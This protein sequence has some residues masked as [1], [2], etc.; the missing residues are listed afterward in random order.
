M[1]KSKLLNLVGLSIFGLL[2]LSFQSSIANAAFPDKPIEIIVPFSAGGG[3]DKLARQ[4]AG[5][6]EKALGVPVVIKNNPG[7]GGRRG[8]VTLFKSKPDGYTIGF[9]HFNPF[10]ADEIFFKKK[11]AVDYK[12][13]AII[14]MVAEGKDLIFVP[15]S[16]SVKTFADLK[17]LNR[18]VK[19]TATGLGAST[20]IAVSALAGAAGFE[21]NFVTGYKNLIAAALGTARGDADAGLGGYRQISGMV[22]ELRPI[23]FF[24]DTREPHFPDVPTVKELGY[25]N[26]AGL[27]SPY[28]ISAP[29]NTPEDRLAVIRKAL[30][31]A[32]KSDSYAK[33]AKDTGYNVS[34]A[35]PDETWKILNGNAEI[36]RSL[37]PLLEKSKK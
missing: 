34:S 27:G 35:G 33:W 22:N 28:V 8:S 32:V 20:W 11:L 10:L 19:F 24:N 37:I 36:Y 14:Q 16:S 6:L 1:S 5:P 31:K 7:S 18:P 26:L 2:L 21:A 17:N 29:P 9:L 23:V 30:A 25:P 4:V 3:F 15:K 12:K 13:I